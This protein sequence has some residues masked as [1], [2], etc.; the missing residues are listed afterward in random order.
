[1]T[2]NSKKE[3]LLLKVQYDGGLVDGKSRLINKSYSRLKLDAEDQNILRTA[4]ALSSLKD[5]ELVN[6][7]KVETSSLKE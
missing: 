2:V 6:V 7:L 3:K 5:Q 1:M 4:Q